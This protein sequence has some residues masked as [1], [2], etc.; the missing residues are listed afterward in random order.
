MKKI[1]IL[2]SFILLVSLNSFSQLGTLRNRLGNAMID[3]VI[4]DTFKDSD[5]ENDNKSTT[6]TDESSN[7]PSQNPG[8]S[9]LNNTLDDVPTALAQASTE[10]NAKEYQNART[11]LRKALRTLDTKVGE[12]LI[13]SL[14]ENV[15]GLQ[16]KSDADRV[17]T[18]GEGWTGLTVRREYQKNDTWAAIT[19]YNG[20]T[21]N[22]TTTVLHASI[23]TSSTDENQK[24]IQIK[25]HDAVI[26][27]SDSEGYTIGITTGQQ[28]LVVIEGVNVASEA[29][30]T[31][32]AECF[33]YSNINKILGDQ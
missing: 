21:S 10:F 12:K 25:G 9:G 18:S 16:V 2:F 24:H 32:I 14:P 15:K 11:S 6:S 1:L 29:E 4:D 22:L 20:T 19:I 31:A 3:K 13:Q 27:F 5:D 30:I 26:T 23:Y 8:G 28:T 17:T 7:K 33:D